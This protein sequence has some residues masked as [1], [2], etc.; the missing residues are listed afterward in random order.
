MKIK[1]M[2]ESMYRE[3]RRPRILS[4]FSGCGG[5][6]LGAE[7]AGG[8]VIW[9]N[10]KD[11]FAC[12]TYRNFSGFNHTTLVEGSIENLD[13]DID[14]PEASEVD[15]VLGGF[16]CQDFSMIW[17]RPGLLGSRGNLYTYFVDIVR[18]KKPLAFVAENVKGL[19]SANKGRAIQQI[20]EDFALCGYTLSTKV[21][22]FANYG[23]PQLRERVLIVGIR[24]DL[25]IQFSPPDPTHAP[26]D[27]A[28]DLGLLN[29]A[30]AREALL[31]VESV[32]HNNEHQNIK[33]KT[34]DMLSLIPPG[35][36][37]S[38]IPKGHPNYVK[39]MISH[40]YRRLDPELPSTT[41]IAAGG[42]GT[43]GYHYAEPRPL[44]NRERARLFGFPDTFRFYGSIS[45]VRRQIGNAVPPTGFKVVARKLFQTLA[46]VCPRDISLE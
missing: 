19:L 45:E 46:E 24:D 23:V 21:Y 30:G 13:L 41:I 39:G 43:W 37:F 16:P 20:Q 8:R 25:G 3:P 32:P 40:V 14:L 34:K 18:R 36:N 4:L 6:D 11:P 7:L 44:T 28:R 12:K 1:V 35:G 27:V 38:S 2:R 42:G 17:K 26:K 22:N 15:V 9:A 33:Q 29:H 31:D 5:M 10:E